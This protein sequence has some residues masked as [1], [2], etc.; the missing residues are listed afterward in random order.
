MF[1]GQVV[2][3]ATGLAGGADFGVLDDGT[4]SELQRKATEK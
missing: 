4:Y 2:R 1:I 3:E